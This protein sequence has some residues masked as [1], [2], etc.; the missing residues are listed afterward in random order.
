VVGAS[1]ITVKPLFFVRY[2]QPT[3]RLR[4]KN[5]RKL[6]YTASEIFRYWQC[7]VRKRIIRYPIL[8]FCYQAYMVTLGPTIWSIIKPTSNTVQS[9][10]GNPWNKKYCRYI[11]W[12]I[13][14][15]L[16]VRKYDG[17]EKLF[18]LWSLFFNFHFSR[19]VF[20]SAK[21]SFLLS[22]KARKT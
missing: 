5:W 21:C 7:S 9:F 15:F 10:I 8:L 13:F 17:L 20:V 2:R 6:L 4:T 12:G 16:K 19:K 3:G 11:L 14:D 18:R 1:K 22:V